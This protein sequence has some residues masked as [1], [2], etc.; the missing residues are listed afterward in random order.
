DQQLVLG[1]LGPKVEKSGNLAARLS[2]I[3]EIAPLVKTNMTITELADLVSTMRDAGSAGTYSATVSGASSPGYI[4]P[5]PASLAMLTADIRA[6][7]AFSTSST[8]L[9]ALAAK[10]PTVSA[11]KPP[12]KVTVTVANGSGISGAAKQAAGVLQT[13]GFPIASTGNANQN[14]YPQTFVIY[15]S[16]VTLA[17]LVA[18]YLPPGTKVVRG[19]G[20]YAFTTDVLVI[21]GKDWD[22]SKVPVAPIKTQ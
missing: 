16:D 10:S 13:Q 1:A 6:Q 12:S 15:K 17:N 3:T 14:V 5:D 22:L 11:S 8:A 18:Q 4:Q 20:M 2:A 9:V 21:I 19:N 7:R